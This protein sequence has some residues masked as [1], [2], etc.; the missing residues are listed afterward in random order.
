MYGAMDWHPEIILQEIE[1]SRQV[2]AAV[3][4]QAPGHFVFHFN[5]EDMG[6]LRADA[7]VAFV[8]SETY[9]RHVG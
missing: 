9:R 6:Q 3:I 5:V 7:F 8:I 2:R 4:R 1:Q